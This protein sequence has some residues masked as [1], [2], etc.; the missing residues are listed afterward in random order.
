MSQYYWKLGK[1]KDMIRT[2]LRTHKEDPA[3][4][5]EVDKITELDQIFDLLLK[6]KD[7]PL[8]NTYKR[9][10]KIMGNVATQEEMNSYLDEIL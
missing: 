5:V 6:C 4:I 3:L 8:G 2:A 7:I 9:I 1:C 10:D